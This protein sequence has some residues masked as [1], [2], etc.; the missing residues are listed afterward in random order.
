MLWL[1][2]NRADA[3]H[4]SWAP[5]NTIMHV[6]QIINAWD[7]DVGRQW[8][9]ALWDLKQAPHP[10]ARVKGPMG[11]SHMHLMENGMGHAKV[12]RANQA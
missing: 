3:T 6:I 1:V 4:G 7:V 9:K 2:K 8:I 10:W 5:V 12:P 11:A